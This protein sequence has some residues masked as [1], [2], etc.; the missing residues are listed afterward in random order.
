MRTLNKGSNAQL[1]E[2]SNAER[3]NYLQETTIYFNLDKSAKIHAPYFC[4]ITLVPISQ[5]VGKI[6]LGEF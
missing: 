4:Q 2:S 6:D 5:V 1:I 3:Q